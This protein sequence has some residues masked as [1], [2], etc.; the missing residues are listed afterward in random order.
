MEDHIRS[1]MDTIPLTARWEWTPEIQQFEL[2]QQ[3]YKK[4]ANEFIAAFI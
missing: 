2:H 1:R 4:D 3:Q